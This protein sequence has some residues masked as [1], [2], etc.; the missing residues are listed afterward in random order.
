MN[1]KE[2]NNLFNFGKIQKYKKII[3]KK[4]TE[5]ETTK[6]FNLVKRYGYKWKRISHHMTIRNSKQCMQ[7]YYNTINKKIRGRW[8]H[9]EDN[10]VRAWVNK[11]G[12]YKWSDCS[13]AIFNRSGKQCRER[14][15]N[16]L[17]PHIFKGKWQVEEQIDLFIF[18][19]SF[20][21]SWVRIAQNLKTRSENLVKN[22][23]YCSIRMLRLSPFYKILK[24]IYFRFG[25]NSESKF[26]II[27][28]L[29]LIFF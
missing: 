3:K 9:E 4:W 10:Q 21:F 23:F 20:G 5:K 18:I 12:P 13:K 1:P 16:F 25:H 22:F 24:Q 19:L 26:N 27:F 2:N 15:I 7:K 11:H 28:F 17:N 29:V 14:W 8:T 6:L